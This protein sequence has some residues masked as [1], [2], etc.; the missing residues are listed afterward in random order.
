MINENT[1]KKKIAILEAPLG[2]GGVGLALV[3]MLD[4]IDYENYEVTLWLEND[5]GLLQSSVNKNVNIRYWGGEDQCYYYI[6][7]RELMHRNLIWCIKS[8][9]FRALSKINCKYFYKNYMYYLKSLPKLSEEM[10]DCMII[11]HG[12]VLDR[13]MIASHRFNYRKKIAWIHGRCS[14]KRDV[15]YFEPFFKEYANMDRIFCVSNATKKIFCSVYPEFSQKSETFYNILNRNM[16]IQKANEEIFESFHDI[17]LVTVGRLSQEKGQDL[18][19]KT[20]R[21][22]LDAG[23]NIKWYLLGEGPTKEYI[24]SEIKKYNVQENVCLLGKKNNPYPYI[25]L[26]TIYVQPSYSEGYCT[27][28]LEAKI[29]CKPIVTTDA[30]GMREQI[31]NT[32]DGIIVNEMTAEALF[33]GITMLLEH[34]RIMEQIVDN[35]SVCTNDN[36][37]EIQKLYSFMQIE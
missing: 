34:P 15:E 7:R 23:Y 2:I 17:T 10:Y 33:D 22:L 19:P 4:Q 13:V 32:Q 31:N 12:L 36:A 24:E 1:S 21:L 29:L 11:F 30:P 28:T 37:Q 26:C 16:I 3:N 20:A 5:T 14:H 8:I 6:L 18:I 25:K 27:S 9:Y 35:L